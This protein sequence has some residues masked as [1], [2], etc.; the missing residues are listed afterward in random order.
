MAKV[1]FKRYET[2]AEAQLADV[3]DG[4]FIITKEGTSYTDYGNE[5][6]AFGG[7]PD[8]QMSDI[9]QNT[10]QNKVIKEY[11]DGALE[12]QNIYSTTERV[13]GT[14]SDGKPLYQKT[15]NGTVSDGGELASNV[16]TLVN[17]YGQGSHTGS[18]IWRVVPYYE[19]WNGYNF[20]LTANKLRNSS[21]VVLSSRLQDNNVS[22][23]LDVTLE[24]T[25][26][27]D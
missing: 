19:Y 22:A 24:Y 18:S 15:I 4:Q 7:T 10:V 17:I 25:K 11:V 1:Q 26:T 16:D 6:I 9:S 2:D 13:I 3:V 5:R 23:E 27:T 21:S 20:I 12:R 14:Y 8:T